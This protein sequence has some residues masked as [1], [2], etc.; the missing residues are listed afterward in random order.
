M[1]NPQDIAEFLAG[2]FFIFMIVL[3]V[4]FFVAFIAVI[5]LICVILTRSLKKSTQ[6]ANLPR[7]TVEAAV[8]SKRTSVWRR[9]RKVSMHSSHTT[10]RTSTIYYVTFQLLNGDC[11]ELSVSAQDYD[12]IREGDRGHLTFQGTQFLEFR[13]LSY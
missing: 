6:N 1:E 12:F 9:R 5:I 11:T 4:L 8:L 2:S 7:V 3:S 13:R 10:V